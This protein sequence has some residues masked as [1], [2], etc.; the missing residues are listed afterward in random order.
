MQVKKY[1]VFLS[2]YPTKSLICI[3]IHIEYIIDKFIELNLYEII[4][5]T[6]IYLSMAATVK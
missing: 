6:A 4:K 5:Q 1:L 3:V 2:L